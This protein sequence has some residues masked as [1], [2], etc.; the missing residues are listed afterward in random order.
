MRETDSSPANARHRRAGCL[1]HPVVRLSGTAPRPGAAKWGTPSRGFCSPS[2]T[3]ILVISQLTLHFSIRG[4]TIAIGGGASFALEGGQTRSSPA[5][6]QKES[7]SK[8]SSAQKRERIPPK[9]P[10]V[11]RLR[12]GLTSLISKYQLVSSRQHV[13]DELGAGVVLRRHLDRG[14]L[15]QEAGVFVC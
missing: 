3:D 15:P 14:S 9:A 6:C 1:S 7:F 2:T 10:L 5:L 12:S 4:A 13:Q 11:S 8:L